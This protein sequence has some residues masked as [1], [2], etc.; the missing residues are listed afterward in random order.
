VTTIKGKTMTCTLASAVLLLS[1]V[2]GAPAPEPKESQGPPPTSVTVRLHDGLLRIERVVPVVE[3]VPETR[4]TEVVQGGRV[5]KVTTTVLVPVS[6]HVVR[7]VT[8]AGARVYDLKG[9]EIEAKRLPEVL[10][11][12]R[13]ALLSADGNPVA[14]AHLRDVPVDTLI[15]IVPRTAPPPPPRPEPR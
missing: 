9:Q 15:V 3:Y 4:T 2:A 6:R 10:K 7:T 12:P 5:M 14:P 1:A 11:Q 13:P 8:V